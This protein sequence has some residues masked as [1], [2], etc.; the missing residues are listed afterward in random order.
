MALERSSLGNP[1]QSL[2]RVAVNPDAGKTAATLSRLAGLAQGV[3]AEYEKIQAQNMERQAQTD[4]INQKVNPQLSKTSGIYHG[5]VVQSELATKFNTLKDDL[6]AGK[7]SD[8]DP[9]DFQKMLLE[10]YSAETEE[11]NKTKYPGI[12]EDLHSK[13]WLDK[14]PV[15]VAAQRAMHYEKLKKN[16]EFLYTKTLSES[17][18]TDMDEEQMDKTFTAL[19]HS[20]AGD[21]MTSEKQL[22]VAL[23]IASNHALKGN[24]TLL[25]LLDKK[26]SVSNMPDLRITFNA[27]EKAFAQ[28]NLAENQSYIVNTKAQYTIM[29]DEGVFGKQHIEAIR[30]DQRLKG[31]ASTE[32]LTDT[33]VHSLRQNLKKRSLDNAYLRLEAG[34]DIGNL[35][36]KDFNQVFDD[37][38]KQIN[39]ATKDPEQRG[40]EIAK[41]LQRQTQMPDTLKRESKVFSIAEPVGKDGEVNP[42]L[43]EAYKYFRALETTKGIAPGQ[44][45]NTF[46]DDDLKNYTVLKSYMGTMDGDFEKRFKFAAGKLADIQNM[47]GLL[48]PDTVRYKYEEVDSQVDEKLNSANPWWKLWGNKTD[49]DS[50]YKRNLYK[51]NIINIAKA[52]IRRGLSPDAALEYSI[53]LADKNWEHSFGQLQQTGGVS[54]DVQAGLSE[55]GQAEQAYEWVMQNDP[56]V[57]A[58]LTKVY[59]GEYKVK[60]LNTV[61]QDG[62]LQIGGNTEE[63]LYLSLETMVQKYR[64]GYVIPTTA[65]GKDIESVKNDDF[66]TRLSMMESDTTGR[67]RF[68]K[69]KAVTQG[70]SLESYLQMSPDEKTKVRQ[71]AESKVGSFT[72]GY[73]PTITMPGNT[74][75]VRNNNPGNLRFAG[76]K[77]ASE[78]AGGFAKFNSV[79]EGYEALKRQIQLDGERGHTLESFINKYAPKGENNPV[80]YLKDIL[81]EL[82]NEKVGNPIMLL[83]KTLHDMVDKLKGDTKVKDIPP[84]VLAAIIAKYESGAEVS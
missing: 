70:M 33:Y 43:S 74:L 1:V 55:K 24:D 54:I 84:D 58:A 66:A 30:Q 29:A 16:Q 78:G 34:H 63:A 40:R 12:Y 15:V 53:A 13:F 14:Q 71:A 76:Q 69:L 27:A 73:A 39:E 65:K 80:K 21:T 5:M 20:A 79:Q 19:F 56:E 75:A 77:G 10:N 44:F 45:N 22:E 2:Q 31:A 25:R 68:K 42:Q 3:T 9:E 36:P 37:K 18:T 6:K 60:D 26:Y 50:K 32:W 38:F 72:F 81:N 51:S 57:K 17:L 59:G 41:Y 67:S 83:D 35:D 48:S 64:N 46:T 62:V 52:E 11:I 28:A 8:T 4:I 7:Y 82:R 61:L 47:S 23:S 49:I